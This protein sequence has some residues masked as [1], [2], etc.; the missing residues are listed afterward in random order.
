MNE[1]G[2]VSVSS[3]P[4]CREVAQSKAG[5]SSVPLK[6]LPEPVSHESET[7]RTEP[8][9]RSQ[10]SGGGVMRQQPQGTPITSSVNEVSGD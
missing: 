3:L 7:S 4:M 9:G 6:Y 10:A 8:L 1:A 5:V 2:T